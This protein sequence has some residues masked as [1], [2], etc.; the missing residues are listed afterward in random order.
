MVSTS[1]SQVADC[2]GTEPVQ[3]RPML[4]EEMAVE[5]ESLF[6]VMGNSTRLRMLHAIVR[7]G[8][9]CVSDLAK[10]VG[11]K[12][13]AVS[14]QLQRLVD[15]RIVASRRNGNNV[16]YRVLNP[17]VVALLDYGLCIMFSSEAPG[18]PVDLQNG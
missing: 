12:P 1:L 16:L 4:T 13:Q 11:M 14:N 2:C 7:S 5:L 3:D 10:A 17:C 18:V 8:E 15:R 6:K 9:L